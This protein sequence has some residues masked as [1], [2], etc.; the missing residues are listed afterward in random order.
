MIETYDIDCAIIGAGVIGLASAYVLARRGREV[1]VLEA[2]ETIGTG[3]SSR[4]SE[5]LHAGI[6]YSPGSLKARLCIEGARLL[7]E[8]CAAHGVAYKDCGKLIVATNASQQPELE[9]LHARGRENGVASLRLIDARSVKQLEPEVQVTSALWSPSSG[10]VD[11]HALML[12][13][14]GEAENAGALFVFKSPV[15]RGQAKGNRLVLD[16]GGTTPS[17]LRCQT[18]VNAAGLA[19]RGIA[20]AIEGI[21]A[22]SVPALYLAKGNYFSLNRRAPF[23]HLIYPI[24]E[25][26]GLGVHVTLDLT[27]RAKFGPDVEWVPQENYS[28]ALQRAPAFIEAIRHYWP[29]LDPYDLSPGYAGI[30]PKLHPAGSPDSDFVIQGP[31]V[32]GIPGLVNLYGIESPGLTACLAIA[33]RVAARIHE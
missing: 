4:N 26:G 33:N 2:A 10:I 23:T 12:A 30:R 1:L 13:L 22:A 21:P 15:V 14:Q 31:E 27:G 29:R 6:Y 25:P 24:P 17:R 5:V 8:F 9:R 18:V 7:R 19:A 20:R 3:I 28:V 32:H 11:S 16:I